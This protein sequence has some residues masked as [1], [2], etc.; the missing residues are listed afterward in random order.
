MPVG[1]VGPWI[2][3]TLRVTHQAQAPEVDFVTSRLACSTNRPDG[4][5]DT[6]RARGRETPVRNCPFREQ[7]RSF[8]LRCSAG[9]C[10]SS[11]SH[12][13]VPLGPCRERATSS[14]ASTP[15]PTL[16]HV[17]GR[18]RLLF[19]SL[20]LHS[21]VSKCVTKILE[22]HCFTF[23]PAGGKVKQL[24]LL[25]CTIYLHPIF[26]VES[27]HKFTQLL[28]DCPVA[29]PRT[30]MNL[31][32]PRLFQEITEKPTCAFR[33]LRDIKTHE[34][35]GAWRQLLLNRS[36]A[37]LQRLRPPLRGQTNDHLFTA[38]PYLE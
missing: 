26:D 1:V 30:L 4:T 14:R 16:D 31:F 33:D 9:L 34:T 15:V 17:F 29:A 37:V 36:N 6:P 18:G 19:Q 32:E 11:S 28:D 23:L 12:N 10:E 38:L 5:D 20:F 13:P 7:K 35:P 25:P 2:P 3:T 21:K 22:T 8:V 24:I 27:A